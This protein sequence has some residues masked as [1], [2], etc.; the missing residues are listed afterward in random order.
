MVGNI[1]VGTEEQTQILCQRNTF[2]YQLSQL[3]SFSK[4]FLR[5]WLIIV[6]QNQLPVLPSLMDLTGGTA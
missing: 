2:P 3:C 6:K 4:I 1:P 5:N